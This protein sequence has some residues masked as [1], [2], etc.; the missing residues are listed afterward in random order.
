LLLAFFPKT[1]DWRTSPSGII[2][3][4]LEG[5]D[6]E[7][8]RP[9][10]SSVD[11]A[12]LVGDEPFL[13]RVVGWWTIFQRSRIAALAAFGLYISINLGV[14]AVVSYFLI[15]NAGPQAQPTHDFGVSLGYVST[16]AII[17]QWTPQIIMTFRAGEVGSLSI[18]MLLLQA[19]GSFLVV[20]F[21]LMYHEAASTWMP[22]FVTGIQQVV[23]LGICVWFEIRD[24]LK[25]RREGDVTA[26]SPA[27]SGEGERLLSDTDT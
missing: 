1:R 11:S 9:Y 7:K 3:D 15:V 17:I 5:S 27:R 16:A 24:R 8:L 13:K 22:Y 10:A 26:A 25:R 6:A 19:P 23:L 20:I 2:N 12:R 14:C 21:Q 4:V 18:P